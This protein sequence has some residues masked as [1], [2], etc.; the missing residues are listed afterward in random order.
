MAISPMFCTPRGI[1]WGL[2][3]AAQKKAT[4]STMQIT[5]ISIGLVKLNEPTLKSGRKSKL[6]RPGEGKPHPL[7][8]WHPPP[9]TA[10]SATTRTS[11]ITSHLLPG[12]PRYRSLLAV[13]VD[14]EANRERQAGQHAEREQQGHVDGPADQPA[15]PAVG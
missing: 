4:T 15:D 8:M 9:G 6:C 12:M 7:K 2:R 11:P 1:S 10:G 13:P 3:N 5:A 14:N